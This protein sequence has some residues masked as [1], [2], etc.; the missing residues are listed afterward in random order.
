MLLKHV[1]HINIFKPLM[2]P[3]R[4][5]R[6]LTTSMSPVTLRLGRVSRE[7]APGPAIFS[8]DSMEFVSWDDEIP[9]FSLYM[10]QTFPNHQPVNIILINSIVLND[11][12][13]ISMASIYGM[14]H[15][16]CWSVFTENNAGVSGRCSLQRGFGDWGLILCDPGLLIS[17]SL[18]RVMKFLMAT[19]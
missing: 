19:P 10:F 4:L 8:G 9:W 17:W 18:F 2:Q 16:F 6:A 7:R 1:E 13:L 3:P 11:V 12:R 15:G 14:F 5:A